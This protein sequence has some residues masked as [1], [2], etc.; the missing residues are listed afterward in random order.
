MRQLQH[1]V[2]EELGSGGFGTVFKTCLIP[3][4]RVI[5]VKVLHQ[6]DHDGN[7]HWENSVELAHR[8]EGTI[9]PRLDHPHI[10]RSFHSQGWGT[11]QV[12]IFMDLMDGT[13]ADLAWSLGRPSRALAD[14]VLCQMLDALDY[15][16][17]LGYVHRDVKPQNIFYSQAP[18]SRPQHFTVTDTATDTDTDTDG[19]L[20]LPLLLRHHRFRLG[21]FGLCDS[22]LAVS[23]LEPR[24]SYPYLAP[25]LVA[26]A[27]RRRRRRRRR[28]HGQS[29]KSDVWAL[30]VTVLWT[31]DVR[32][33]RRAMERRFVFGAVLAGEALDADNG[34]Q[35][36]EWMAQVNPRHRATAGQMLRVLG[37]E[38][39]EEESVE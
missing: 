22:E 11:P 8:G 1:L 36:L 39:E 25:E 12:E 28:Q 29:H 17:V 16:R 23:A 2:L 34:L 5:A 7:E 20:H 13:L 38:E 4:R 10:I 19:A 6:A 31:L 35:H 3:S 9:L 27:A 37:W 18:S 15:L 30:Y 24:G 26:V 14:F 32:G 21:D 33:L